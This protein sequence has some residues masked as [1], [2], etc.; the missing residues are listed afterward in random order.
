MP[1]FNRLFEYDTPKEEP[2]K[3]TNIL[4]FV[5]DDLRLESEANNYMDMHSAAFHFAMMGYRIFYNAKE[6]FF[7]GLELVEKTEESVEEY[8]KAIEA[9]NA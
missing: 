6:Y 7:F 2:A 3:E 4:T 9:I 8:L 1:I 5:K